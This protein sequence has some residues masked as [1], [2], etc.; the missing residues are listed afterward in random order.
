MKTVL[1][2]DDEEF[3][4]LGL[5][6]LIDWKACGFQI[7]Y[8][9][10]NGEDAL[11]IIQNQKPDVVITDIRMPVLS[12]LE[13]IEKVV[14]EI[15]SSPKFIIISGYDDF[16]YAQQAVRYGVSDY[17]LKPIEKAEVE[18]ILIKLGKQIGEENEIEML[19][20]QVN[21]DNLFKRLI[22]NVNSLELDK[23]SMR[24]LRIKEKNNFFYL[25]FEFFYI[26]D[27]EYS[28]IQISSVIQAVI[29]STEMIPMYKHERGLYGM[30]V[31]SDDLIS[32]ENERALFFAEMK[33]KLYAHT[34]IELGIYAGDVVEELG[35]IKR[36][37]SEA[38]YAKNFTF[39]NIQYQV[40]DYCQISFKELTYTELD[41]RIY[42][43]LMEHI[44]NNNQ[45][46]IINLIEEIFHTFSE[47]YFAPVAVTASINRC[48]HGV[49]STINTLKG[50]EKR[51][52]LLERMIHWHQVKLSPNEVKKLL[53][54]FMLECGLYIVELRKQ[55]AKGDIH[56][57]KQY[58]DRHFCKQISLKSLSSEFYL[59]S[60]YLGQLFKK[61]YGIY[62][63]EYLL[64][65][66]L[67]EAK[68]QLRLTNKRVYEISSQVGFG[69]T[70][71]FVTLFERKTGTT[72]TEYRNQTI[73]NQKNEEMI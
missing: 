55:N 22:S 35:K 15:D 69:S 66:R 43:L 29:Q 27:F 72:P 32:F 48:I 68:K 30:I 53:I 16:S 7:S 50:D 5:K 17:I 45:K 71:Y 13:L 4:R 46:Q 57:I 62:F 12:G 39:T 56:I 6:S 24:D 34:N 10:D 41:E 31:N 73:K 28:D 54:R 25:L 1:I 33:E 59:N 19:G 21:T 65:L 63:K 11:T 44:E 51:L 60:V 49:V 70:D 61:T 64:E 18:S 52:E 42:V 20:A 8:E 37:F 26:E 14:N 3:V 40:F 9:A 36:S 2:V 67:N 47:K 23:Q 58:I 38:M